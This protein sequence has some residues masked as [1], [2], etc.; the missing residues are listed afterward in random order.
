M[1]FEKE[2]D[3]RQKNKKKKKKEHCLMLKARDNQKA[4]A[5][6]QRLLMLVTRHCTVCPVP[7]RCKKLCLI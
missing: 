1:G 2:F 3:M 7:L 4:R 5:D 6:A